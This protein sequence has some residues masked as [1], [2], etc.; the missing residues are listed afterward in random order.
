MTINK[1]DICKKEIKKD[2]AEFSLG[3]SGGRSFYIRRSICLSCGKPITA[4]VKKHRL[5][6]DKSSRPRAARRV[7]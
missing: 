3:I 1:C 2:Q 7:A 5:D 4:F 6:E